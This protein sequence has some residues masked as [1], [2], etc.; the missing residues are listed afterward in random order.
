MF[1]KGPIDYPDR[2]SYRID[3]DCLRDKLTAEEYQYAAT[4]FAIERFGKMT[5][6][7]EVPAIYVVLVYNMR[8]LAHNGQYVK[9]VDFKPVEN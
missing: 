7:A 8:E 3:I 5:T 2:E 4:L 6:T 9:H 1:L